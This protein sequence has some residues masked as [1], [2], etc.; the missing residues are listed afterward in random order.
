VG[1]SDERVRAAPSPS[2]P[3]AGASGSAH[4]FPQEGAGIPRE[5]E[6]K[7]GV[8]LFGTLE[9]A[10]SEVQE[11]SNAAIV[12]RLVE[13]GLSAERI[14]AV[15]RGGNEPGRARRHAQSHRPV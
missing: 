15:Q 1:S 8:T 10:D 5:S 7:E 14:V 4:R 11:L 3:V 6:Q 9:I 2:L 13:T 12:A